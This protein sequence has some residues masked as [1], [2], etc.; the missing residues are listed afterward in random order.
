MSEQALSVGDFLAAFDAP[1]TESG[2]IAAEA[3]RHDFRYRRLDPAARDAVLLSVLRKLD[4]FSRVGEHRSDIW[5]MA[6]ADVARRYEES[7]GDLSALEPSFIGNTPYLR[8]LGDYAVPT[9]PRFEFNYFRVLRRWLF[10]TYLADAKHV[11]EFGC[12]SGFNLA[13]LAQ[14]RPDCRLVGLDWAPAAVDLVNRFADR[15]GFALEGR[16]FDFFHPDPELVLPQGTVALTFCALEQTGP[17]FEAFVDWLIERRPA[18]VVTMEPVREFYDP[19]RLFDEMALRYHDRRA[20]LSG[21]Q[22]RLA[23]LAATGRIELLKAKRL[24]MGSL[25]H[26][27][28]SLLAWRPC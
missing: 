22:P 14:M 16:R 17:R 6:W 9:D 24:G 18:L 20:Y 26:E 21:Y 7:R 27:G 13:A 15:H 28:Y 5:Q 10:G 3:A 8:L 23:A 4:G 2:L 11:Y 12:G 19:E 25:Y 1:E